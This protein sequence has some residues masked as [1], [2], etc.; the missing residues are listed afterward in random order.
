MSLFELTPPMPAR[1]LSR[2][3]ERSRASS[4]G[5]QAALVTLVLVVWLIPVKRYQFPVTLPFKLEPY[6]MLV[7][8]LLGA[9]LVSALIGRRRI[10][11][12][13]HGKAVFVLA[14]AALA[15][16]AANK[17]TIDA[18]GLQTQSLKALSYLF[19]FLVVFALVCSA[20]QGFG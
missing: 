3:S 9:L 7:L 8:V 19:S 15:S 17:Q 12:A 13:G 18:I 1:A 20:L 6:R 2:P 14:A 5:W 11:A 10:N 4:F 16:Q